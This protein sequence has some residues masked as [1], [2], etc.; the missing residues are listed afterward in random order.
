ME[1]KSFTA[2]DVK[3]AEEPEIYAKLGWSGMNR[4]GVGGNQKINLGIAKIAEIARKRRLE[5]R[6]GGEQVFFD[7]L[8][9]C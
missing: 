9:S 7:N 1:G 6:P 4:E 5:S 8:R 3:D 2:K